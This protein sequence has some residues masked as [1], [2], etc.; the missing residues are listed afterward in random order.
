[1]PTVDF[2]DR[3]PA[4]RYIARNGYASYSS[5]CLYINAEVPTKF[6]PVWGIFGRELHS[7]FLENKKLKTLSKDE[8]KILK[9]MLAILR[10]SNVVT[11]LMKNS[12]VEQK[13]HKPLYGQMVLGYID[14]LNHFIADLK[15]TSITNRK[16]F[17]AEMNFLQA[18]LY[19]AVTG[20][21][22]FYYIGI[23]KKAPYTLMIFNVRDYPERLAV[24]NALLKKTLTEIRKEMVKAKYKK[25]LKKK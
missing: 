3:T 2:N 23:L 14:I 10:A 8:E 22:D 12:R 20:K 21:K 25:L 6:N 7:R 11:Q 1:M 19:L 9:G 24:A 18:A 13:F 16:K 4:L 5:M 17:I 15:S